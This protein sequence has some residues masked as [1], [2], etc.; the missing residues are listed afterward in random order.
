MTRLEN[1]SRLITT[2]NRLPA[3]KRALI[4]RCLLDG[5]SMRATGRVA[6]VAKQTVADLFH[7][8]AMFAYETQDKLLRN[9]HCKRLE[10]DEIWSF[11]HAKKK[12]VKRGGV[13]SPEAGDCWTWIAF[14]P[15]TKLAP[16]WAIGDRTMDT[17]NAFLRDLAMRVNRDVQLTSD[18]L[19][20]YIPAVLEHFG[21]QANY[22]MLVKQYEDGKYVGAD[23][24]I[25]AG[26]PK[27]E[28][29]STSGI[30]RFNFT[31][32]S[33]ARRFTRKTNA[34]SKKVRNHA[35]A[36]AL[37][38]L[39]YNFIRPHDTIGTAPA[40]AAGIVPEPWTIEMVV[41]LIEAGAPEPKRPKHYRK[42]AA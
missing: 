25:I 29:V 26:D 34:Y 6:E 35:L 2:M 24:T 37:M 38:M 42:R 10:L 28:L 18:G 36:V 11:V 39:H 32:R 9:I 16:S 1:G 4:L 7:D 5:T 22:A 30:E 3:Q 15:D 12:T 33:E 40:V 27:M 20:A 31:L 17:A 21:P 41:D 13:T 23:K 14:D 8:A 19:V